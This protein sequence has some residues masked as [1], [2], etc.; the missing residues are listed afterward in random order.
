MFCKWNSMVTC[1]KI[2][3]KETLFNTYFSGPL[4]SYF[5]TT[6]K[7]N[8]GSCAK[9]C[10]K[11][12]SSKHNSLKDVSLTLSTYS[13]NI[14]IAKNTTHAR[15]MEFSTSWFVVYSQSFMERLCVQHKEIIIIT[16]IQSRRKI[17][18]VHIKPCTK[19]CGS[20]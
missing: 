12:C 15:V 14:H 1:L 18:N 6:S 16:S 2:L 10:Q 3:C 5:F 9:C 11:K 7:C 13:Q 17:P 4:F 19:L 20:W 8:C